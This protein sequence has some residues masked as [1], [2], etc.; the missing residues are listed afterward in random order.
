MRVR[1]TETM[2]STLLRDAVARSPTFRRLVDT[3]NSTNGIVY[4]ESGACRRGGIHACLLMSLTMAGPNRVLHV[5][6]DTRA[7]VTTIIGSIG[8]ELQHVVEALSEAGVTSSGRLEAFFERTTGGPTSRGH[9][10]FETEAAVHAG[11]AVHDEI[12]AYLNAR[13]VR[14]SEQNILALLGAGEIRSPTFR[15]L[16]EGLDESDVIIYLD[17]N[18]RRTSLYGYLVNH[19]TIAGR[20]RYLRARVGTQGS[21]ERLIAVIAHELEHATEVAGAADVRDDDA[22]LE[23][24]QRA[25]LRYGCEGGGECFE[26]KAARDLEQLVARELSESNKQT[27]AR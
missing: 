17:P 11:E 4:V 18:S 9:L 15:H 25:A 14:S 26:T 8:H 1:S 22:L 27:T 20:Y 21:E 10:E 24:F 2:V 23:F 6:V 19:V 16:L 13:H 7:D 5:R 3:V 12:H